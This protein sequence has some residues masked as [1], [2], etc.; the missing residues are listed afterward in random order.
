MS[1][2]QLLEKIPFI[3]F[4]VLVAGTVVTVGQWMLHGLRQTGGF[5]SSHEE[6]RR[7][8]ERVD[9]EAMSKLHRKYKKRMTILW[10]AAIGAIIL[11]S[12]VNA[13]IR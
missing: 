12:I 10:L 6:M 8:G 4:Y 9:K 2:S 13:L 1:A 7:M 11:S 5:P 3:A